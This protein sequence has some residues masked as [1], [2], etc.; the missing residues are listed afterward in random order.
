[1][2]EEEYIDNEEVNKLSFS[3]WCELH[4]GHPETEGDFYFEDERKNR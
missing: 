2:N 1:M 3:K 4:C